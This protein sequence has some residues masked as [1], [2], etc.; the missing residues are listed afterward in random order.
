MVAMLFDDLV[1]LTL[2]A[3]APVAVCVFLI[4]LGAVCD[5]YTNT[6]ASEG[7]RVWRRIR[8][9]KRRLSRN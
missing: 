4:V 1:R 2:N 3:A 8:G 6:V 9:D 7:S 5:M